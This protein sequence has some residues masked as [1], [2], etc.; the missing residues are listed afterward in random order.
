MDWYHPQVLGMSDGRVA[1]KSAEESPNTHPVAKQDRQRKLLTATRDK[2]QGSWNWS[3][4]YSMIPDLKPR[5]SATE[6]ILVAPSD[7]TKGEK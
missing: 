7:A 6:T 5:E 4:S 2:I 1:R 3:N